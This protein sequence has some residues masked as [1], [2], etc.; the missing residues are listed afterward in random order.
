LPLEFSDKAF[1]VIDEFI[2]KEY[3]NLLKNYTNNKNINKLQL[4]RRE[5]SNDRENC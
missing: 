4:I 1:K 3:G 2:L 5:Y